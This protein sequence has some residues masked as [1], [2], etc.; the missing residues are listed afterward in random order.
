MPSKA[1]AAPRC[2]PREW[3]GVCQRRKNCVLAVGHRGVCKVGVIEEEEYEVE[4]ILAERDAG[5]RKLFLVKWR[6]WPEDDA[7]WE[8]EAAL[9]GAPDILAAWI[10]KMSGN[11]ARACAASTAVASL[12]ALAPAM[13]S[14]SQTRVAASATG[15]A[16]GA[17]DEGGDN[18]HGGTPG[19]GAAVSVPAADISM[20]A[21]A[22]EDLPI[23]PSMTAAEPIAAN[24]A[25]T[26]A[27]ATADAPVLE[28][29]ATSPRGDAYELEA[30]EANAA[31]TLAPSEWSEPMRDV[32]DAGTTAEQREGVRRVPPGDGAD[33]AFA[34]QREA[35]PQQVATDGVDALGAVGVAASQ[36]GMESCGIV[37]R[38]ALP[39]GVVPGVEQMTGSTQPDGAAPAAEPEEAGEREIG[40]PRAPEG[41]RP[42][43]ALT[44]ATPPYEPRGA[45]PPSGAAILVEMATDAVGGVEWTPSEAVYLRS[46]VASFRF[47]V[48]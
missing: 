33:A 17:G 6:G 38:M 43:R 4:A 5:K 35:S 40:P 29:R 27:G 7:T 44:I 8:S 1:T 11:Q 19:S 18:E 24:A 21:A 12:G 37:D 30:T 16:A 45:L 23:D 28:V 13:S 9:A 3:K 48:T 25:A 10:C 15:M 22:G 42:V 46:S 32:M 26:Q 41:A 20:A 14:G 31:P 2:V 34:S 47:Q 36:S 39:G